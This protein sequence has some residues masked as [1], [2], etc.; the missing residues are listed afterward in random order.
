MLVPDLTPDAHKSARRTVCKK[1]R[2]D[3]CKKTKYI[4]RPK[5][6]KLQVFDKTENSQ[7]HWD[8]LYEKEAEFNG[9]D[10]AK[11]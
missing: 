9:R 2:N 7:I 4:P 6:R 5:S 11:V 10:R 8:L 1:T 3:I